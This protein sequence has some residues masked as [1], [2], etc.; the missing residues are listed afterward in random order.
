[1]FDFLN[2]GRLEKFRIESWSTIQRDQSGERPRTF[3]ALIN[4]DEFTINYTIEQDTRSPLGS[5]GSVGKFLRVQPLELSVKLLLDGTGAMGVRIDVAEEI[6]RFYQAVGYDGVGHR[7][8]YLRITWGRLTLM[9]NEPDLLDCC[10]K[11]ASIQYKLFK[12][13]GSPLRA[14]INATFVEVKDYEQQEQERADSS[15]DL[16]HVR[17]V[18][19]GDTLPG[20]TYRIYGD[21]RYYLEVARVNGLTDFRNLQ[22]GTQ[23]FFPPFDK[24]ANA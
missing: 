7:T 17:V 19:D 18:Q 15:P 10:L 13:D 11:T 1:M 2:S 23:L 12:P 8:R 24:K 22:P 6:R 9:R 4:P 16:T 20:M 21:I 14:V 5:I 3:R